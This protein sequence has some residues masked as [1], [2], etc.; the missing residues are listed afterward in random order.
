MLTEQEMF[1]FLI[2]A[3][4]FPAWPADQLHRDG[5][6][7][8]AKW[9]L[10]FL[11]F[12]YLHVVVCEKSRRPLRPILASLPLLSSIT[13][14][15]RGLQGKEHLLTFSDAHPPPGIRRRRLHFAGGKT[16][17]LHPTP[18]ESVAGPKFLPR[19]QPVTAW[20][21]EGEV[22]VVGE[23]QVPSLM[24]RTGQPIR[25]LCFLTSLLGNN[26]PPPGSSRQSDDLPGLGRLTGEPSLGL[27]SGGP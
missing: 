25:F 3:E 9:T 8:S 6:F 13:L 22:K 27:A 5:C 24:L 15:T 12:I 14:D 21:S 10:C 11:P 16:R 7:A 4:T 2:V 20:R 26:H 1:L 18:A 17:G 19:N 23:V